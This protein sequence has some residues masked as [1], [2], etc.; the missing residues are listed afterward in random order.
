MKN[1]KVIIILCHGSK[2][3]KAK[4]DFLVFVENLKNKTHFRIEPS[5]L[6]FSDISLPEVIKKLYNE[7]FRE[8]FILPFFL[9]SGNHFARDIPEILENEKVKYPAVQF[10]LGNTLVPD[11]ELENLVANR[12]KEFLK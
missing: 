11:N 4:N 7:G 12:I 5:F 10:F 1:K 9:L 8:I 3:L 6:Q 2:N